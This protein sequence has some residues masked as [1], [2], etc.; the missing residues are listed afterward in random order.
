[1]APEFADGKSCSHCKRETAD[2]RLGTADFTLEVKCRLRVK[3]RLQT[4]SKMQMA[5]YRSFMCYFTNA[6]YKLGYIIQA[7]ITVTN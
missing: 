7:N 4:S 5:D 6:N 3:C 1:M 2:S